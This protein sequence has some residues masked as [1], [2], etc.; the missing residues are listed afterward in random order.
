MLSTTATP[1]G[2]H[3]DNPHG[4]HN[5]KLHDAVMVDEEDDDRGLC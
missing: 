3:N 4:E 2:E 5:G 1:H